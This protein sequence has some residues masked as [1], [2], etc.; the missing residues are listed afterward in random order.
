MSERAR[1]LEQAL[2][3]AIDRTIIAHGDEVFI[4]EG[5]SGRESLLTY[6]AQEVAAVATPP[7][8]A[9]PQAETSRCAETCG[10][11]RCRLNEGHSGL[12]QVYNAATG[13]FQQFIGHPA[14]V[15]PVEPEPPTESARVNPAPFLDTP[16]KQAKRRAFDD[17]TVAN[18]D[19]LINVAF[20]E[21]AAPLRR[22]LD[23][24]RAAVQGVSPEAAINAAAEVWSIS[25]DALSTRPTV[26]PE[27]CVWREVGL[28]LVRPLLHPGER[29]HDKNRGKRYK[30]CPY[31]GAP[32]KVE[33]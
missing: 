20:T 4:G 24:I 16:V 7:S 25:R 6:F 1:A 17:P 15:S 2:N 9:S 10:L 3:R 30:C 31:C 5:Y 18:L 32:L 19:A 8:G 27:P 13:D 22:A 29:D 11:L 12:H 14:P 23:R 28:F 21:G 33:R 26:E